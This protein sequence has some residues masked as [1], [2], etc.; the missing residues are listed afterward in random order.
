[1]RG[2]FGV[3]AHAFAAACPGGTAPDGASPE[4]MEA[5]KAAVRLGTRQGIILAYAISLWGAAHY[6]IASFGITAALAKARA[7][8]GE[9]D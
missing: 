8:R 9:A 7:D 6:F 4:A 5:C 2:L 1:V 3:D